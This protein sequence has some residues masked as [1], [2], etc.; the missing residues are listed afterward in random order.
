MNNLPEGIT[1]NDLPGNR[2]E[3]IRKN[4]ENSNIIE[5]AYDLLQEL[6]N[7]IDE[8]DYSEIQD[9][10]NAMILVSRKLYEHIKDQHSHVAFNCMNRE[11]QYFKDGCQRLNI[12]LD[13][14][15]QC[16]GCKS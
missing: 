14:N 10:E 1:T 16:L 2:P 7:I 11:C 13:K 12:H 6:E 3:D 9:K 8:L 15:G 5:P 4:W